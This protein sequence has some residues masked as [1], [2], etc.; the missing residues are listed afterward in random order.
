MQL[1]LMKYKLHLVMVIPLLYFVGINI[2]LRILPYK[3]MRGTDLQFSS[4]VCGL[5]IR[6][7]LTLFGN[8]LHVFLEDFI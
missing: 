7:S 4:R 3:F 5:H 8:L 6:V 1:I 2:I